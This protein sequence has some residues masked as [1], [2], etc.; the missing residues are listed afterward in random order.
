MC[1]D[2]HYVCAKVLFPFSFSFILCAFSRSCSHRASPLFYSVPACLFFHFQCS[3]SGLAL[4]LTCIGVLQYRNTNPD[5]QIYGQQL[6]SENALLPQ[7]GWLEVGSVKKKRLWQFSHGSPTL[8]RFLPTEQEKEKKG[9][10]GRENDVMCC[11]HAPVRRNPRHGD[12]LHTLQML[13]STDRDFG[14]VLRHAATAVCLNQEDQDIQ[15]AYCNALTR[16][17]RSK[18]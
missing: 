3:D 14:T 4:Q 2:S 7:Q 13:T 9:E 11:R 8:F 6:A 18:L 17:Q 5:R 16:V 1:V 10:K 12:V 15:P